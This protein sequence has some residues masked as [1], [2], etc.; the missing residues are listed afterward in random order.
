MGRLPCCDSNN[1]KKGPW[2]QEEDEKLVD[3]IKNHGHTNWKTLPKLAGLNRCGKSCRLRWINYLRPDIKRGKFTE[4]EERLIINLHS[5][6]GNKTDYNQLLDLSQLL[7]AA[8]FGN[9]TSPWDHTFLKLQAD[10]AQLAK[11]Q[12]LQNLLGILSATTTTPSGADFTTTPHISPTEGLVNGADTIH[13]KEP[14]QL[15]HGIT[16]QAPG[17]LHASTNS[18]GSYEGGIG[19]GG[20]D[21]IIN[22]SLSSSWDIQTENPLPAL[23]SDNSAVNRTENKTNPSHQQPTD[24]PTSPFF[25][26]WEKLVDDEICCSSYWKDILQQY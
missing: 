17:N 7:G 25:E 14:T 23:V 4:E 6:L 22:N 21:D 9:L 2:T 10:A 15:I 24:S 20:L 12:L 3:Y 11:I 18:W 19:Q 5:V 13:S 8:Q 16:P 26:A 1:L